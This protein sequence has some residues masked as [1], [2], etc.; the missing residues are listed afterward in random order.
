MRS[1]IA[2]NALTR[3][4]LVESCIF[5]FKTRQRSYVL[6]AYI[7]IIVNFRTIVHFLQQ[8]NTLY[9]E[10]V[11]KELNKNNIVF[12][13]ICITQEIDFS[14]LQHLLIVFP[15][16]QY[17]K[18]LYLCIRLNLNLSMVFSFFQYLLMV[19]DHQKHFYGAKLLPSEYILMICKNNTCLN[20]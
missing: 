18:I 1:Q 15:T 19:L 13:D 5:I 3:K 14:N 20:Y 16:V 7:L 17:Y 8:F 4:I 11:Q 6:I 12:C 9:K 2:L 10:F